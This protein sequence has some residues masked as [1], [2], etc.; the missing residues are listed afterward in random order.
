M[1]VLQGSDL[2]ITTDGADLETIVA[3][4]TDA[5]MSEADVYD[6]LGVIL[7]VGMDNQMHPYSWQEYGIGM[8]ADGVY[9]GVTKTLNSEE[10]FGDGWGISLS[11]KKN[12]DEV[13]DLL[14]N[15]GDAAVKDRLAQLS[16]DSGAFAVINAAINNLMTAGGG[17]IKDKD[18]VTAAARMIDAA[19]QIA[20]VGGAQ[21]LAYDMLQNR[22]DSVALHQDRFYRSGHEN[23]VWA[24]ALYMHNESHDMWNDLNGDRKVTADLHGIIIGAERFFTDKFTAGAA[25]S[26]MEGD[27]DTDLGSVYQVSTS[28]DIESFAV[29]LFGSYHFSPQD[30]I[31]AETAFQWANNDL[32]MSFPA[33]SLLDDKLT[34]D[35]DTT[36]L[37]A[38][39]SYEHDFMFMDGALRLTPF[40]GVGYTRLHTEGYT[41]KLGSM[42]AFDTESADQDIY[43]VFAGFKAE[44]NIAAADEVWFRP[45]AELMVKPNFGDTE[46]TNRVQGYGLYSKDTVR[47]EVIG[48]FTYGASA[49]VELQV[50]DYLSFAVDYSYIGSSQSEN[51]AVTGNVTFIF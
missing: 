38:N 5:G 27:A 24:D 48:E 41:S 8:T 23:N 51:H 42:R 12:T 26:Y 50:K 32:E 35:V 10:L 9:M 11:L 15:S 47:P 14:A 30:R 19:G 28:N 4:L 45:R 33:E 2:A 46:V 7:T 37:Q 22:H 18:H 6:A 31:V 36:A 44:G 43:S 34:A 49:G 3:T 17:Q 20:T 16:R 1:Q 40:G 13:V 25:L 39:V 21:T 29:T